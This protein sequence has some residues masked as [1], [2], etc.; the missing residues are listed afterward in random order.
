MREPQAV[1]PAVSR[2][3]FDREVAAYR[4]H[5][6]TFR[7]QGRFLI[8][9]G[10]PEVFAVFAAAHLKPPALVAGVVIDFTDY[11]LRPP[12]VTFVDPL[13]REPVTKRTLGISMFRRPD[14]LTPE[15]LAA[16]VQAGTQLQLPDL[17]QA[18]DPDAKPFLCLPGTREYHDNPAHTGDPWLLHRGSSEGSLAF[19]L[20]KIW[21]YGVNPISAFQI[22]FRAPALMVS[23]DVSRIPG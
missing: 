7:A 13:T 22:G 3:K 14:G 21:S 4:E 9:A 17:I 5:E 16:M 19:I 1:D 2:A 6:A 15:A 11:D 23:L 20:E 10:F 12:S 8:E 18:W